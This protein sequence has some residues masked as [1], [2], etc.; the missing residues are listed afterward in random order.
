MIIAV[1]LVVGNIVDDGIVDNNGEFDQFSFLFL[2]FSLEK[3]HFPVD[4]DLTSDKVTPFLT[5]SIGERWSNEA[6]TVIDR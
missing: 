5:E 2:E 3:S 6:D 4:L 1:I